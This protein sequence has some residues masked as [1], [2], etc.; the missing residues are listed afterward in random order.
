MTADIAGNVQNLNE[1]TA[2][3]I[4]ILAT[5][6]AK[7]E[8]LTE[9]AHEKRKEM[10]VAFRE[11]HAKRFGDINPKHALIG[12]KCEHKIG[13][14][15]VAAF[16]VRPPVGAVTHAVDTFIATPTYPDPADAT[17]SL[18]MG[19]VSEAERMHLCW[20]IGVHLL[21]DPN[22]K[23]QEIDGL[24]VW[25]RL[26]VIRSLPDDLTRRLA[27]EAALLQSYLNV[28]LEIELGNF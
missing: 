22:Q 25:K 4:A 5:L 1:A 21:A 28:T 16:F 17:K 27:E 12:A 18:N 7:L 26:Q 9:A 8:A 24:P 20:L 2:E 10:R 15:D 13:I 19:P 6:E 11:A 3:Q 23:R 14:A